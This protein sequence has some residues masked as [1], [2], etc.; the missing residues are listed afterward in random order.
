MFVGWLARAFAAT[1]TSLDRRRRHMTHHY[2]SH[3]LAVQSTLLQ[4]AFKHHHRSCRTLSLNTPTMVVFKKPSKPSA[5][6]LPPKARATHHTKHTTHAPARYSDIAAGRDS[7]SESTPIQRLLDTFELC[8][9]VLEY[10]PMKDVLQITRVCRVFKTNIE[11]STRLQAKLFLAPDR[12][13]KR[14]VVSPSGTLL[15]GHRIEQYVGV[16]TTVTNQDIDSTRFAER[17]NAGEI[18]LYTPHPYLRP[19]RLS[20]RYKRM[21]MVKYATVCNDTQRKDDCNALTL[22]LDNA[23]SIPTSSSFHKMLLSQPPAVEVSVRMP[24]SSGRGPQRSLIRTKRI[25]NGSGVT[26][27]NVLMAIRRT[28]NLKD[29][30]S[31]TKHVDFLLSRGF[32]ANEEARKVLEKAGE[33]SP[34]DDPT[35]WVNKEDQYVLKEGGFDFC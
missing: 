6:T 34:Y 18:S 31:Y 16:A 3:D 20:D 29:V 22:D 26:M 1:L 13:L 19:D 23:L 32:V 28:T 4:L 24:L 2:E 35:R 21:G 14:L 5:A 25:F 7:K 27:G 11:N 17:V 8:E 9:Q 33:L 12:T 15:A 10:L 30:L